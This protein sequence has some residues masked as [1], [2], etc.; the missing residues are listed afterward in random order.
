ML[1]GVIVGSMAIEARTKPSQLATV[2]GEDPNIE[3]LPVTE[4]RLPLMMGGS[5]LVPMKHCHFW[6][7]LGTTHPVALHGR[8]ESV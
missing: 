7:D 4:D 8:G 2:R 1:V 5:V 3:K 6:M